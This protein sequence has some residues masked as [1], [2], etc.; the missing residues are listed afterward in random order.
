MPS[1]F[2]ENEVNSKLKNKRKLSSF[3]DSVARQHGYNG[4]VNLNYIFC[5][6][7]Y[8]LGINQSYLNHDTYTDIITFD[9]SE[10]QDD[11]VGEIYISVDRIKE[12]A[13]KFSG[14]YEE[15]LH[16]VIFHGMLHLCGFKDKTKEQKQAMREQ[17]D[18][19]LQQYFKS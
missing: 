17:E 13:E 16:R 14:N 2:H 19:C 12:N 8:L 1:R 7:E 3:L 4:K 9:M 18:A 5:T 15:E 11:I 6:D 10:K